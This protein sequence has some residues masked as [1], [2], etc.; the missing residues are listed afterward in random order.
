MLVRLKRKKRLL[1]VEEFNLELL[2][3]S[4]MLVELALELVVF[5]L[6]ENLCELSDLPVL[7]HDSVFKLL[8]PVLEINRTLERTTPATFEG[9]GIKLAGDG[10]AA[11]TDIENVLTVELAVLE[12]AEAEGL[13]VG[14]GWV[15][16]AMIS[17]VCC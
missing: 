1:S 7:P 8:N 13:G 14:G 15:H 17:F 3:V 2:E 6:S 12:L 16:M 4:L 9:Y 10:F 5:L 11:F